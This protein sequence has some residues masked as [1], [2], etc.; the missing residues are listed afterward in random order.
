MHSQWSAPGDLENE[1]S[2]DF[3]VRRSTG[4]V[5]R[6]LFATPVPAKR[7][8]VTP[9]ARNSVTHSHLRGRQSLH[10][11]APRTPHPFPAA[12]GTSTR[13]RPPVAAVHST[14]TVRN[15]FIPE[16]V[17]L[18]LSA[19]ER[20]LVAWLN[21]ELRAHSDPLPGDAPAESLLALRQLEAMHGLYRSARL[22]EAM[23]KII[24]EIRLER[25]FISRSIK[26]TTHVQGRERLIEL[27]LCNY[28]PTWLLL[29][30]CAVFGENF[31][32]FID[33]ALEASH[34]DS[35]ETPDNQEKV[36][37]E[38]L[39]IVLHDHLLAPCVRRS[40]NSRAK[41]SPNTQ[42]ENDF[43]SAVLERT[44]TLIL[45]LDKAKQDHFNIVKSDPPLFRPESLMRSSS[46]VITE[47][48]KHFLKEQGDVIRFLKGRGYSVSYCAPVFETLGSLIITNLAHDMRDGTR[49]CKL[50]SVMVKDRVI[51]SKI[52]QIVPSITEKEAIS[53]RVSNISRAMKAMGDYARQ[54]TSHTVQWAA[55]PHEIATGSREKTLAFLWQV[56]ALW[57]ETMV[58]ET[59]T[60]TKELAIVED[61]CRVARENQ[62]KHRNSLYT[63]S[64]IAG[65]AFELSPNIGS[66]SSLMLYENMESESSTLL[67]RWCATI[68]SIYGA[69][70]RDFTESFRDG[71]V[72][73]LLLYHYRR[74]LLNLDE[75]LMVRGAELRAGAESEA[76]K[77]IV[78]RNFK[79]FTERSMYLGNFPM[80]PV[81]TDVA[82][83]R[84]FVSE[85]K[86]DTFGRLMQLLA[87]YLFRRLSMHEEE[88]HAQATVKQIMISEQRAQECNRAALIITDALRAQRSAS[89]LVTNAQV[90]AASTGTSDTEINNSASE[91]ASLGY[92]LAH[93][94]SDGVPSEML[95]EL[96]ASNGDNSEWDDDRRGSSASSGDISDA[97]DFSYGDERF[98]V[99]REGLLTPAKHVAAKTILSYY[100]RSKSRRAFL[101]NRQ[102]VID[103]QRHV[104]GISGRAQYAS[105]VEPL[106]S[107]ANTIQF[108]CS[109]YLKRQKACADVERAAEESRR[110]NSNIRW[111]TSENGVLIRL[112]KNTTQILPSLRTRFL[113]AV[114]FSAN[115][116]QKEHDGAA[117]VIQCAVRAK[118]AQ[119]KVRDIKEQRERTS[120]KEQMK[121]VAKDAALR[122]GVLLREAAL[123]AAA[124][125][126]EQSQRMIQILSV[127]EN[128]YD[129]FMTQRAEQTRAQDENLRC[130][131]LQRAAFEARW[132]EDTESARQ[133][134][135]FE[136][137]SLKGHVASLQRSVDEIADEL[138]A[139]RAAFED[140]ESVESHALEKDAVVIEKSKRIADEWLAKVL[141][142][143][144]DASRATKD[145]VRHALG[146]AEDRFYDC[147]RSSGDACQDAIHRRKA[148]ILEGQ[149]F[150]R[151]DQ[152]EL[153]ANLEEEVKDA[154]RFE[155]MEA[156][157]DNNAMQLEP[158]S[159]A[160]ALEQ[161]R[162]AEDIDRSSE[163]AWLATV[164]CYEYDIANADAEWNTFTG[165][166][167]QER[168][169]E[170]AHA[171][172]EEAWWTQ[173]NIEIRARK[174]KRLLSHAEFMFDLEMGSL[175]RN[176]HRKKLDVDASRQKI[177][178]AYSH[179]DARLTG[180]M[181]VDRA[182]DCADDQL[183]KKV[184]RV[185]DQY[186]TSAEQYANRALTAMDERMQE[187]LYESE[188]SLDEADRVQ[189]SYDEV[190][191]EVLET[192]DA[193]S[194]QLALLSK[195]ACSE[196]EFVPDVVMPNCAKPNILQSPSVEDLTNVGASKLL[197]SD[198][199]EGISTATIVESEKC[200][201]ES[202][203]STY[204]SQ[205]NDRQ[206]RLVQTAASGQTR[207]RETRHVQAA[208]IFSE[209][210]DSLQSRG[211][212]ALP[213]K[214]E[215]SRKTLTVHEVIRIG[216]ETWNG[217]PRVCID[218]PKRQDGSSDK[219]SAQ[220]RNVEA[221]KS[222]RLLPQQQMLYGG[223]EM[224]SKASAQSTQQFSPSSMGDVQ[225][226]SDTC[227]SDTSQDVRGTSSLKHQY[228]ESLSCQNR[229]SCRESTISVAVIRPQHSFSKTKHRD[230]SQEGYLPLSSEPV[231]DRH[232]NLYLSEVASGGG[233][234][235]AASSERRVG[236]ELNFA[237]AKDV[238]AMNL[239]GAFDIAPS[240]A[241]KRELSALS[242]SLNDI[243]S[244]S[245]RV[246]SVKPGTSY[247]SR[248]AKSAEASEMLCSPPLSDLDRECCADEHVARVSSQEFA[249]SLRSD[250][251]LSCAS[252]TNQERSQEV[253][254]S[255]IGGSFVEG[256]SRHN[257]SK[258]VSEKG[259]S[260]TANSSGYVGFE[261]N[262]AEE[263]NVQALD[264]TSAV[265]VASSSSR[266]NHLQ[267]AAATGNFIGDGSMDSSSVRLHLATPVESYESRET[268]CTQA[269]EIRPHLRVPD[270][271][272]KN[273]SYEQVI[274]GSSRKH[275]ISLGS[276][277][278]FSRA[279]ETSRK[280][281]Q[282]VDPSASGSSF[283]EGIS[284][285]SPSKTVSET[286]GS[287]IANSSGYVGHESKFVGTK[288]VQAMDLAWAT[289]FELNGGD[290]S[291]DQVLTLP[292]KATNASSV[293]YSQSPHMSEGLECCGKVARWGSRVSGIHSHLPITKGLTQ[294]SYGEGAPQSIE[295]SP[296]SQLQ[297]SN[298]V[299]HPSITKTLVHPS[300]QSFAYASHQSVEPTRSS[301]MHSSGI[302][303]PSTPAAGSFAK[304]IDTSDT[305]LNVL[306]AELSE[307]NIEGSSN[308]QIPEILLSPSSMGLL[309]TT[310]RRLSHATS[311]PI[312]MNSTSV[313][314]YSSGPAMTLRA[315]K[316]CIMRTVLTVLRSCDR[317]KA[318]TNLVVHGLSILRNMCDDAAEAKRLGAI[319]DS[320]DVIAG[321]VQLYRDIEDVFSLAV[322]VLWIMSND[323]ECVSS[324]RCMNGVLNRLSRVHDIVES[325]NAR[326]TRDAQRIQRADDIVR[327]LAQRNGLESE[328]VDTSTQLKLDNPSLKSQELLAVVCN[329][330]CPAIEE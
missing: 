152:R 73:C 174:F 25:F 253:H 267:E 293:Q 4:N 206:P 252:E 297:S 41:F 275:T 246:R 107:A 56:A 330:L 167:E 124:V 318:Q 71:S 100:R 120:L 276:V 231:A 187:T 281:S 47:L 313:G 199:C 97:E 292:S 162:I 37:M 95:D 134:H 102:A 216:D 45:L 53:V 289:R 10:T 248:E 115:M 194:G 233:R 147:M 283:V 105:K 151:L 164:S 43:N 213:T 215:N 60:L 198:E 259:A 61:H 35:D 98:E 169:S 237:E 301:L 155:E 210:G 91:D 286:D 266:K 236:P 243:S 172:E 76:E 312:R 112:L 79:L 274:G 273:C 127:A 241:S 32:E 269:S 69:T 3:N 63:E 314:S 278:P 44:L 305:L 168:I 18:W 294:E 327:Y 176:A 34:L 202:S 300:Q 186:A 183:M 235:G 208:K 55:K 154:K 258:T 74:D 272:R 129:K 122:G 59:G 119:S 67:L 307:F 303:T 179:D 24:D 6:K 130:N 65:T 22:Q 321:C 23:A 196:V 250:L 144:A 30:L 315:N 16:D 49:L 287:S 161:R 138:E 230:S 288:D 8:P 218:A 140:A 261:L 84:A 311:T 54:S 64:P 121:K 85:M 316:E 7:T 14:P 149:W 277:H 46:D 104:R 83:G 232:S 323:E 249:I 80:L 234:R 329:R 256:I 326:A 131:R 171:S 285:H 109:S 158:L 223:T 220:E 36:V 87:S 306:S 222:H 50:A 157:Y 325:Q 114:D 2:N 75:I 280:L 207:H 268:Q 78:N 72:L 240:D 99:E 238:Q 96:F 133:K 82:L 92:A 295:R 150:E 166:C 227:G 309:S 163:D 217:G 90:Y 117:M 139:Q 197:V 62:K 284:S 160:E 110:R 68:A 15:K 51:L 185:R 209:P 28:H 211:I 201:K 193:L 262:S 103:I 203:I 42:S 101:K 17:N 255:A 221:L 13:R 66:P 132:K 40:T 142:Y 136:V 317:S 319:E 137:A 282:E 89:D 302:A 29:A 11:P 265:G 70:V 184:E 145:L 81:D 271:E 260:S 239:E 192:M 254:L 1:S 126:Q 156:F 31:G 320:V 143:E 322:Q 159:S 219:F 178:A 88:E 106:L 299:C 244:F 181:A 229:P 57:I 9:T 135:E 125:H 298:I 148:Y 165:F 33:T 52:R 175:S 308:D 170:E 247:G 26:L 48:A 214:S 20:D 290:K 128:G 123:F 204:A 251:R 224:Q 118:S 304:V 108:A 324:M 12:A 188:L 191:R 5:P 58:L 146:C 21:W 113:S 270:F 242:A 190:Q 182:L 296:D 205:A 200:A 86:S 264:S 228:T 77:S 39:E 328:Q 245:R 173:R 310:L 279:S 291:E 226:F 93:R 225:D 27:L 94:K 153:R 180:A 116:F 195:E 141:A 212:R 263:Q 38:V 189:Q 19:Q 177:D 257:P 111:G